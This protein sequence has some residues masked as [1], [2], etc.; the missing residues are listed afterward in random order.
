MSGRRAAIF[1]DRDNTLIVCDGY[2]GDPAK[3]QLI[4]GAPQ[5][6]AALRAAGFAII[7][8]SNQSG[9]A[10]GYFDES[11]VRA[12]NARMDELL[13]QADPRAIIDRHEYCP[14]HPQAVVEVYR[15][16]SELRKPRP[17]MLLLAAEALNLDLSRSW[18]IGDAP[19]DIAAGRAAGCRTIWVHDPSLAPSSAGGHGPVDADFQANGLIEAADFII[20]NSPSPA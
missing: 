11:A 5:A 6:V 10:R 4:E 3:V 8:C 2:L 18:M 7:T 17:G 15:L 14:F 9:V 1:L 19:H 16:D 12:V 13:K 20:G